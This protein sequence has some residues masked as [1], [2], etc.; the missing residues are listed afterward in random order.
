M[1]QSTDDSPCNVIATK[2]TAILETKIGRDI[3][4]AGVSWYSTLSCHRTNYAGLQFSGL[5]QLQRSS[6]GSQELYSAAT[7]ILS[8]II[9]DVVNE[10]PNALLIISPPSSAKA[11]PNAYS[12]HS[13]HNHLRPRQHRPETL[14]SESGS[15]TRVSSSSSSDASDLPITNGTFK[16]GVILPFC[17]ASEPLLIKAT[18]NCTGHGYPYLKYKS[19]NK[20][21]KNGTAAVECWSCN[22]ISTYTLSSD[23]MNKT[24]VWSGPACQKKD[25]SAPF[26][27][28]AGF[29]IFIIG[30]ASWGIGLLFGIGQE[31]L[32]GVI[33]AG[34]AG[35]KAK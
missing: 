31:D 16:K 6:S 35:P 30:I 18:K 23:G 8:E 32:P 7:R 34:V 4:E 13:H 21:S 9:R 20:K 15:G 33:G 2:L 29:T 3:K 22:C 12:F 10:F 11:T 28:I 27:L 14:L 26:F 1:V 24:T 17:H 25:V 19:S 5:K